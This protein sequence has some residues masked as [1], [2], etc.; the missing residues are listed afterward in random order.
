[1]KNTPK[2]ILEND[3]LDKDGFILY[4]YNCSNSCTCFICNTI[5]GQEEESARLWL[6]TER[7][8]DAFGMLV[9][10][11]N[12]PKFGPQIQIVKADSLT[13]MEN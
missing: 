11:G 1:M 5:T 2:R 6:E 4:F 12:L 3:I 9:C 8:K 13:R 10:D 7:E